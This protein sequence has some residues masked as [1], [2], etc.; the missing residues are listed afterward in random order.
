MCGYCN[1][2]VCVCVGFVMCACVHV[3]VRVCV[4]VCVGFVICGFVCVCVGFV[5]CG[6][7]YVWVLKCLDFVM[8]GCFGN[9]CT[10]FYCAFIVFLYN[11]VYVHLFLFVFSVLAEGL[12]PLTDNSI[13]VSE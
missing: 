12:P 2:C 11:F 13:A 5:L 10:S 6:C 4:C 8:F 3:W 1:V 7:V 9:M